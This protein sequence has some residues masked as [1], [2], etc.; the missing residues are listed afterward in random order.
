MSFLS[1]YDPYGNYKNNKTDSKIYFVYHYPKPEDL[2]I[3]QKDFI[4]SLINEFEDVLISDNFNDRYKGYRRYIDIDS[5]VDFFI[6]NELSNNV[7]AYRLSTFIHKDI[8][9]KLTMGPIWDY[10]LAF[11]NANYCNGDAI[12]KWMFKFNDYCQG[13]LWMVPFWWQRLMEDDFFKE[14][15]VDRWFNLR[16]NTLSNDSIFQLIEELVEKLKSSGSVDR[17]FQRWPILGKWIWP[18]AFVGSNYDEEIDYL[19]TWLLNRLSW[20][21]SNIESL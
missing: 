16:E 14:K 18:N 15:I 5:F 9:G 13:D 2:S 10:N 17:N 11:G 6:L 3:E 21:D 19:S 4:R 12:D 20:I 1:N 7:D 8:S